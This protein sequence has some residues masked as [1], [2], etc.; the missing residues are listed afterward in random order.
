MRRRFR[1]IIKRVL[2]VLLAVLLVLVIV[3]WDLVSYGAR[4][5]YGQLNIVWN[6]KPVEEFLADPSFPDSLKSQLRLINDIRKFAIDSLG[7]KDT[8]NYKT[9]YD[10]KGEEI[11]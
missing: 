5:G 2:L 8:E 7:L 4:Q 3:F 9:M 1:R 6:A 11:M 10:Q